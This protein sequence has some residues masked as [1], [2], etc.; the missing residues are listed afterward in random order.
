M[1]ILSKT[2]FFMLAEHNIKTPGKRGKGH[3]HYRISLT[4]W[5]LNNNF[6]AMQ[7][8]LGIKNNR[9]QTEWDFRKQDEAKKHFTM[10][11]LMFGTK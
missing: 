9:Y 5:Y 1:K 11:A 4:H 2:K 10:L 7:S 6:Y 8:M 3:K